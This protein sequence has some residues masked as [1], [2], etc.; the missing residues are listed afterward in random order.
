MT[1]EEEISKEKPLILGRQK[2]YSRIILGSGKYRS[3]E[4]M[5]ECHKVS[6]T[7]MVTVA[8]RRVTLSPKGFLTPTK[9]IIDYIDP[10]KITLLP[11]TAGAQSGKEALR[12]AEIAHSMG[13]KFLKIEVIKEIRTLLPEPVETLSAVELI[14]KEFSKEDLFLMV[15]TNDDPILAIKLY[16]AGADCI[17]PGGSPIGSGRG[18]Q[19]PSNI[20]LILE[21]LGRKLP[22]ILD[23]GIGS[24]RDVTLAMELGVDAILLNSAIALAKNPIEMAKAMRHAWIA[25]FLSREGGRI[26]KKLYATASS[27]E[28]DF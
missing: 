20:Q 18:I 9:N 11:N 21:M 17:M 8:L 14:R 7:Q 3:L 26:E 1:L 23:A 25:G 10:K 28:L 6:G 4:E 13:M 24:A 22:V 27:P 19:N 15:Y 5:Q 16:E 12:L 2:F